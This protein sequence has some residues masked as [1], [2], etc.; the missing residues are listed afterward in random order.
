MAPAD[1][2]I[3]A[4][5]G[6][7]VGRPNRRQ[8]YTR[9]APATPAGRPGRRARAGQELLHHPARRLRLAVAGRYLRDFRRCTCP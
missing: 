1:P 2:V 4:V 8:L 9:I 3:E 6:E 5:K 7:L